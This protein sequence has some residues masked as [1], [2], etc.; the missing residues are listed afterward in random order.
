[1]DFKIDTLVKL[2]TFRGLVS[3]PENVDDRENYWKLIGLRGRIIDSQELS[4]GRI[5]VLFEQMLNDFTVENH[6][7]VQNSS[8]I[9][10]SDLEIISL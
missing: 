5:L 9:S 6:N 4:E 10:K 3:C 7:P 1:M 8:W 2:K